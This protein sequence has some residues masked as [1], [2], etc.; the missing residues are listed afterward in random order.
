M[1]IQGN[2]PREGGEASVAN[3][4]PRGIA[5]DREH[6]ELLRKVADM[7]NYAAKW[8]LERRC[9]EAHGTRNPAKIP[10]ELFERF[11]EEYETEAVHLPSLV[12]DSLVQQWKACLKRDRAVD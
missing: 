6:K 5:R 12:S 1:S 3:A 4:S 10:T 8:V 2:S 9:V 7:N 11:F